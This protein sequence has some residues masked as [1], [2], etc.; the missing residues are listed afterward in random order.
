[1]SMIEAIEGSKDDGSTLKHVLSELRGCRVN[2][3]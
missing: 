1:M 2:I 3:K